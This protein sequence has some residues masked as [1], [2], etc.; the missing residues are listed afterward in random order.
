MTSKITILH[1]EHLVA[2]RQRLTELLDAARQQGQDVVRLEGKSLDLGKLE[3]V[4]GSSSLFGDKKLLL[5]EELHSLP[6]SKRKDQLIATIATAASDTA[7]QDSLSLILWEKRALTAT[8]LK[9]F[10]QAQVQEFKLSNQLFKWLES[11]SPHKPSKPAQ[12]KLFHQVLVT[13]DAFLC[14]T[15]LIRQ[16]RLLI[17]TKDG[18]KPAGAPFMIAK[19]SKQAQNFTLDQLLK[20]HHSL[21]E[22]DLKQK[23]SG[24]LLSLEQE[25][26]LLL[27]GL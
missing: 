19:L 26:D 5:I 15:M 12:L 23:T 20:M 17:Q 3:E 24:S 4:L 2:S 27:L 14:L 6:K 25:L 13:E 11:L 16:V 1:G 22:I 7:L 8:M 21:L 18:G 10:P 9:A